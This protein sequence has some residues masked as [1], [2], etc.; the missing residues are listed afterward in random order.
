MA[1]W[2]QTQKN[3]EVEEG[4]KIPVKHRMTE[5]WKINNEENKKDMIQHFE[6]LESKYI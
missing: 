6:V 5:G 3:T 2:T 1:H 4:R